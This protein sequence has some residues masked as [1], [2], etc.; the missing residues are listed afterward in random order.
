LRI[1]YVCVKKRK[2]PYQSKIFSAQNWSM[3]VSKY[4]KSYAD[5]RSEGTFQKKCTEKKMI[6]IRFFTQKIPNPRVRRLLVYFF[7]GVLFL[8][9]SFRFEIRIKIWLLKRPYWLIS[10]WTNFARTRNVLYFFWDPKTRILSQTDP[11]SNCRVRWRD[12]S[13]Y[14]TISSLE[15]KLQNIN[16][17]NQI[18]SL[19]CDN[20]QFAYFLTINRKSLGFFK[21]NSKTFQS[22]KMHQ[23]LQ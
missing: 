15:N 3:W 4:P 6:L 17:N 22:W 18:I 2:V 9:Y 5:F 21:P 20:I 10:W 23:C 16:K 7:F 13:V 14:L 19:C 11:A 8:I 1:S 12:V